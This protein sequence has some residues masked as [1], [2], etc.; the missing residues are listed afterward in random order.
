MKEPTMRGGSR[1]WTSLNFTSLLFMVILYYLGKH[2]QWPSL[3]VLIGII[4]CIL[5][6]LSFFR[7]FMGTKLWQFVHAPENKL[8]E[9]EIQVVLRSLKYSYSIFTIGAIVIIYGFALAVQGPI[10]V[11]I[12]G[13]L[14][15]LA[16]TLPAAII[17]W[18]GR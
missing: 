2:L 9:R 12:A 8:D 11:I 14:L 13:A 18:Q 4:L 17:G 10:D 15:Y 5:F 6:V 1:M 7:A 3:A 16:H